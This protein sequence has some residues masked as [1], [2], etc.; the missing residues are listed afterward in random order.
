MVRLSLS[1]TG[2]VR[3]EADVFREGQADLFRRAVEGSRYEREERARVCSREQLPG[4]VRRLR[5]ARLDVELDEG[6]AGVLDAWRKD[7]WLDVRSAEDRIAAV[8]AEIR[9]EHGHGLRSYQAPGARWLSERVGALL[10]DDPRMGKSLTGIVAIPPRSP[11]LV[12]APA[13]V[14]ATTWPAEF[15]RWRPAVT[16]RVLVGRDSFRWP[17]EAEVLLTSYEILPGPSRLHQKPCEGSLPAKPCQGCKDVLV[18]VG[19]VMRPKHVGHTARCDKAGN[20][21]PSEPCPGCHP[22]LDQVLPGTVVLADEVHRGKSKNSNMGIALRAL[23][24]AARRKGGRSWGFSGTPLANGPLDL[25]WIF[26]ALGI[27][28]EAF[29]SF[30]RFKHL[31]R[32]KKLELGQWVW[33]MPDHEVVERIQ[34]VALRRRR[35]DYFHELPPKQYEVLEVPIDRDLLEECDHLLEEVGGVDAIDELLSKEKVP[36]EAL[37]ETLTALAAAKIPFLL[38]L[39]ESFEDEGDPV[40]V[41]SMHSAP[42]RR[43]AELRGW[44]LLDGSVPTKDR[45]AIVERFEA[46]KLRGLACAIDAAGVGIKLSRAGRAIFV[47]QAWVPYKNEQAEDRA[48]DVDEKGK[49]YTVTL[50]K[51]K[52]P[53]DA[54]ITEVLLKKRRINAAS[55]DAAAVRA[56]QNV[57]GFEGDL[58]RMRASSA[59]LPRSRSSELERML[60]EARFDDDRARERVALEL[61]EESTYA[62]LTP[63]GRELAL[64]VLGKDA[65]CSDVPATEDS[66]EAQDPAREVETSTKTVD[67]PDGAAY[68]D[69]CTVDEHGDPHLEGCGAKGGGRCGCGSVGPREAE[70]RM[71]QDRK[72]NGASPR[73]ERLVKGRKAMA[74]I[75]VMDP[76]EL[77]EFLGMLNDYCCVGCAY[78]F[79]DDESPED[80][81]CDDEDEESAEEDETD[82]ADEVEEEEG[83][84]ESP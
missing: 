74:I 82:E 83:E 15:A 6:V 3:L 7:R 38:D 12:I 19:G 77:D 18:R 62:G 26:K 57:A 69:G 71:A 5:E 27:A 72:K 50:L 75:E 24:A 53:L 16:P 14:K 31:F 48:I 2:L 51:A 29:G 10:A 36:F 55:V 79:E 25:W 66:E 23:M 28:E 41:F 70:A 52:H 30:D 60:H 59:G 64:R 8:D 4:I 61:A 46:G 35:E 40:L 39:L 13:T 54:R 9:A 76:E 45:P 68:E 80:H 65:D 43:V 21:L 49:A 34:R 78:V 33:G 11:V 44:E 81:V 20:M 17:R 1:P 32:G 37:S 73:R 58:R 22:M 42:L 47:D 63:E 56:D 67:D 84:S